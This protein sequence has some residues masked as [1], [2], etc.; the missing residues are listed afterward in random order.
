MSTQTI[1]WSTVQ[2]GDTPDPTLIE[3]PNDDPTPV[4]GARMQFM[5]TRAKGHA[6]PRHVAGDG[7]EV[8]EVW[9]E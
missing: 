9:D 2:V 5:C 6:G 4:C 3:T 7:T 1:D 8:V